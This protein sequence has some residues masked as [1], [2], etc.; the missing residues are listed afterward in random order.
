[1]SD[2]LSL[3]QTIPTTDD[4]WNDAA[5]EAGERMIRGQILKFADWRW[6]VGKEATPVADGKRL[7]ALATSAMWVRWQGGKPVQYHV[8][9]PGQ[10]LPEREQ[11]GHDNEGEWEIGPTGERID[12]WSNT[13]LV[14]L[15]DPDTAEAFT[16]STSSIGGRSAVTELGD[17][18]GRM[19]N[20]HFDALPIVEL[21]AVEMKTRFGRKSKPLLKVIGWKNASAKP[22]SEIA[23][24]QKGSIKIESGRQAPPP[25]SEDDYGIGEL[26]DDIPF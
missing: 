4:G 22:A 3:P 6:M 12:P 20:A 19:R 23:P 25:A 5:A 13:R 9:H 24:S 10:R 17:Q 2:Y 18:I 16:F 7:V 26:T 21:R 14:Y 15:V 8:R 1:M 11:L